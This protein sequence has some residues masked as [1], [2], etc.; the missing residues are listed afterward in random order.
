LT[1]CLQFYQK[2]ERDGC[3]WCGKE[4]DAIHYIEEYIK[5]LK[6]LEASGIPWDTTIVEIPEGAARPLFLERNSKIREKAIESIAESLKTHKNPLNGQFLKKWTPSNLAKLLAAL[7]K[8]NGTENHRTLDSSFVDSVIQCEIKDARSQVKE[9]SVD[10]IL[11]DPPYG[12]EYLS[13]WDDLGR[14]AKYA[15]K[16]GCLLASYSGKTYL[17]NTLGALSKYLTYIW[18]CVI[19]HTESDAS[20]YPL[21]F[22]TGWKPLVLFANGKY[23]PKEQWFFD[24]I[25]GSGREKSPDTLAGTWAQAL[26]ESERLIEYFTSEDS[27]VVDPFVGTGTTVLAAKAHNRRFLGM[28]KDKEAVET[29]IGR[30]SHYG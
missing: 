23:E 28:D 5:L 27:L 29:T 6:E 15:L 10:F 1:R 13:A 24:V 18:T 21:H 25:P 19:L 17:P 30:L 9:H 26:G 22:S 7:S 8:H 16:D 11:T 20:I 12:E 4:H 14:F 3:A 2:C